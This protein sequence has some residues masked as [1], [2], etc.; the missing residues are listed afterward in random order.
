MADTVVVTADRMVDVIAGPTVESGPFR[1]LATAV[2]D[3]RSAEN[4]WK[5]QES[6]DYGACASVHISASAFQHPEWAALQLTA[7]LQPKSRFAALQS[8]ELSHGLVRL[9]LGERNFFSMRQRL[10]SV[11]K[12]RYFRPWDLRSPSQMIHAYEEAIMYAPREPNVCIAL[13]QD[14]RRTRHFTPTVDV[15]VLSAA[16]T[17]TSRPSDDSPTLQEGDITRE[18]RTPINCDSPGSGST[19]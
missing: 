8:C 1:V 15:G 16:D 19:R 3:V 11:N 18:G 6:R 17:A 14:P 9:R 2:I 4:G 10:D 5:L 12:P 13:D 7:D